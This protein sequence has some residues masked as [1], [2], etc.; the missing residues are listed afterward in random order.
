MLEQAARDLGVDPAMGFLVGDS[1]RD[2][3]AGNA[4]GCTTFLVERPDKPPPENTSA[5]Y[6]VRDLAAAADR[7]LELSTEGESTP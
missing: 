1:E 2:I 5:D 6:Q 7:I 3:E 4:L